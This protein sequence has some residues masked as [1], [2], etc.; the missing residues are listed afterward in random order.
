MK[1]G[2]WVHGTPKRASE[3]PIFALHIWVVPGL[4]GSIGMVVIPELGAHTCTL[5]PCPSWGSADRQGAAVPAV[6]LTHMFPMHPHT[7]SP[8][9]TSSPCPP[10]SIKFRLFVLSCAAFVATWHWERVLRHMFPAPVPPAKGY[11]AH[12]RRLEALRRQRHPL[13]LR[14][15][16]GV[17]M[18][19]RRREGEEAA[20]A[21][22]K[23]RD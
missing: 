10:Q 1:G 18:L 19:L 11:M 20:R 21:G 7:T 23:K 16:S 5:P 2:G 14:L 12:G 9:T 17:P 8:P 3:A 22:D 4:K 15:E 13:L 6:L